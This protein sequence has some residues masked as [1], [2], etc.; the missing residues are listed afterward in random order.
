[1]AQDKASRDYW[2]AAAKSVR[3][4]NKVFLTDEGNAEAASQM[5]D[6]AVNNKLLDDLGKIQLKTRDGMIKA[7]EATG[8]KEVLILKCFW[9]YGSYKKELLTLE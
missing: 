3:D 7:V 8:E 2:T 5:K 4:L 9:I 1:M 6:A